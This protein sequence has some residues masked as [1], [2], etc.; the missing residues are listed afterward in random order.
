MA[1]YGDTKAKHLSDRLDRMKNMRVNY[2]TRWERIAEVMLPTSVGF[3]GQRS[4]GV[5][6]NDKIFDGTGLYALPRF[7]A[8]IDTLVTPHTSRWH[9]LTSKDP[10]VMRDD[11]S[12]RFFDYATD[13]LFRA[14]YSPR[15][16]FASKSAE[17]YMMMG[18]F[19]NG[20]MYI[21]DARPGIRYVSIHLSEVWFD[22]NYDGVIDTVFWKH[23]YT[24]RQLEGR[25]PDA[26]AKNKELREKA[27]KNPDEKV[28]VCKAVRPRNE[29]NPHERNA[30]NMAY[31]SDVFVIGATSQDPVYLEESGYRT[32]PFA[33]ARYNTAP[34]EVYA[35]G[36]GDDALPDVLTLQAMAR[37][38]LRVGELSA[39]PSWL[40]VDEESLA[41]FAVRPGGLIPGGLDMQG[42]PR[43]MPLQTGLRD[44]G[45]T[46][47]MAEQ[48]RKQVNSAFLV[49]LFQ[50]LVETSD[51]MT[52]T[53]VM[54]RVQEKGAMLAPI[55]GRLRTEY[56]GP[57]IE[58]EL[59]ILFH[60][61]VIDANLI[62]PALAKSGGTIDI[63][64]D[65][66]LTRAMRAE[67]GVGILRTLETAIQLATID[68]RVLSAI[69]TEETLG[70]LADING[71]PARMLRSPDERQAI[72]EETAMAENL[73]QAAAVAPGLADAAK[74]AV[75]ANQLAGTEAGVI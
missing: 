9:S 56:L 57:M 59:D 8:A 35:R 39:D 23:E 28:M 42:R 44:P 66:P 6:Q 50:V 3:L 38:M 51:R 73:Q 63:E 53:E 54:Q 37:T 4:A 10:S 12:R 60:A 64:Y 61:G 68:K 36:P 30:R 41:A 69:N 58:R 75:E 45:F 31:S 65:S 26:V 13:T 16:G 33:I 17:T 1:A 24:A 46:L 15:A 18:A 34:R 5:A 47:E 14:R 29:R 22:E 49:T 19:G 7:T 11:G 32:F 48:R 21:R 40:T 74:T 2:D 43:V 55:S 70:L 72:E 25:W 71:A 67:E 52:A 20:V 62:P 27:E